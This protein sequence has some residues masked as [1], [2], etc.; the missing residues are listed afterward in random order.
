MWVIIWLLLR[1]I[2]IVQG[3]VIEQKAAREFADW[4]GKLMIPSTGNGLPILCGNNV[5]WL[6][7]RRSNVND[8]VRTHD[9]FVCKR[10]GF[11]VNA[12]VFFFFAAQIPALICAVVV[13]VV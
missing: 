3:I 4:R 12:L 2:H 13:S 11:A 8:N 6:F 9:V 5:N 1:E 7:S 10:Q